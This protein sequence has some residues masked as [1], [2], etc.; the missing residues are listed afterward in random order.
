LGSYFGTFAQK[1]EHFSAKAKDAAAHEK[2][3]PNIKTNPP[4]KGTGY[5]YLIL[6][7]YFKIFFPLMLLILF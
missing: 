2:E 3:K 5:G 1:I 6:D 7:R 4:K